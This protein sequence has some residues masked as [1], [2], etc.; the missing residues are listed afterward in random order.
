MQQIEAAAPALVEVGWLADVVELLGRGAGAVDDGQGIQVTSVGQ[1][2]DGVV[3][4]EI[5]HTFV[6]R[7]PEHLL[8]SVPQTTATDAELT[9][10]ID[11]RFDPQNLAELVVH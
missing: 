9:W 7:T 8:A 2:S 4:V 10:L 11:D 3:L 5:G 1:A 6:H